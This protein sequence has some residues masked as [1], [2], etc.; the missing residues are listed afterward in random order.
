M[1]MA[2]CI[3]FVI[4]IFVYKLYNCELQVS[5]L[6][7][8]FILILIFDWKLLK[9]S[10]LTTFTKNIQGLKTYN[11]KTVLSS[12]NTLHISKL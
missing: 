3:W 7:I 11:A 10:L 8:Y 1:K 4:P 2:Y 5:R 9:L 12:F 6:Y